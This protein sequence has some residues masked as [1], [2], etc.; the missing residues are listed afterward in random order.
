[1]LKGMNENT[2]RLEQ[3]QKEPQLNIVKRVS[4]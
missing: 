3:K 1:M 4:S 2:E